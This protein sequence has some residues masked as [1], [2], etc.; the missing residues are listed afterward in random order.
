MAYLSDTRIPTYSPLGYG[1]GIATVKHWF[2]VSKE[3][4]QLRNM[5]VTQL[6]DIGLTGDQAQH[7][8]ARPFWTSS[9]R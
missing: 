8:A 9:Q 4:R 6:E 5:T 1:A 3:R 2:A 7:E